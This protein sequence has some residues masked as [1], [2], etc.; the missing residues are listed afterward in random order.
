[1]RR[2][3]A[4]DGPSFVTMSERK[5]ESLSASGSEGKYAAVKLGGVSELP[6]CAATHFAGREMFEGLLRLYS[7]CRRFSR[8]CRPCL[9]P[10]RGALSLFTRV[11][12][13]A[14]SDVRVWCEQ[15]L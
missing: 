2:R 5:E 1:M 8:V 6:S 11:F 15:K 7:K 13:L 14:R 12:W 9:S 3:D 10:G 4:S